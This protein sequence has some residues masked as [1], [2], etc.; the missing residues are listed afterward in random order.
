[1]DVGSRRLTR[2]RLAKCKKRN[3]VGR[4]VFSQPNAFGLIGVDGDVD[5]SAMIESESAMN[6]S[7]AISTDR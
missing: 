4:Q 5:P 2:N 3:R 7:L 6:R 1:M